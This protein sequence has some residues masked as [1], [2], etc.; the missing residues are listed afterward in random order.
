VF[1]QSD[2][3]EPNKFASGKLYVMNSSGR[4]IATYELDRHLV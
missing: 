1:C 3:D 4:T 2:T